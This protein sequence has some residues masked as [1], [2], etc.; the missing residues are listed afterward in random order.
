MFFKGRKRYIIETL[1][2]DALRAVAVPIMQI[3]DDI[4]QLAAEMTEAM[5]VFDGIGIAAP[6]VG[7]SLRLIVLGLP[8]EALGA[9]PTP[10]ELE[11]LPRM[12]LALIN[13]EVVWS[14]EESEEREEGCLSLP[15]V[16][17]PVTRPRRVLLRAMALDGQMLSCECGNLLGRCI[18]HEIDHLDGRV[19]TDRVDEADRRLIADDLRQLEKFGAKHHFR[20]LA[21]R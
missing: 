8:P 11:L 2:S 13:P 15:E 10:G 19:F 6:Q 18:Q 7:Q 20:R 12:P 21:V 9:E 17:A 3:T 4:R 14:S 1:G 16:F 5:N